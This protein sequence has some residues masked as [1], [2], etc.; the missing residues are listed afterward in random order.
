GKLRQRVDVHN[1]TDELSGGY[2]YTYLIP[3]EKYTPPT[4]DFA[5]DMQRWGDAAEKTFV[6][7]TVATFYPC[8]RHTLEDEFDVGDVPP[9]VK[10]AVMLLVEAGTGPLYGTPARV[11]HYAVR[12]V[13]I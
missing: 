12:A 3:D 6:S 2:V 1:R 10:Y 8:E 11:L 5:A 13:E 9:G 4:C 7:G